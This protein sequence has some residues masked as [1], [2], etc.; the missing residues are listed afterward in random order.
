MRDDHKLDLLYYAIDKICLEMKPLGK[1][2]EIPKLVQGGIDNN[3]ISSLGE[4]VNEIEILII[5]KTITKKR[6]IKLLMGMEYQRN[7]ANKMHQE[8]MKS[9]KFRT[10][11]GLMLCTY[12]SDNPTKR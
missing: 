2:I 5:P 9:N 4:L 3:G 12:G 7:K 6:F 11:I 8:Y 10:K 1:T